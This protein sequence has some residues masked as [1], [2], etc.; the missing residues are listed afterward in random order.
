MVTV[1]LLLFVVLVVVLLLLIVLLL[2]VLLLLLVLL[3]VVLITVNGIK[4]VKKWTHKQPTLN[5]EFI[6]LTAL[7]CL[8]G[9]CEVTGVNW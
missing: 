7:E 3:V 9:K 5:A 2:I 1:L 8:N 4:K 6:H